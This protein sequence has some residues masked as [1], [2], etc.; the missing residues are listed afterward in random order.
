MCEKLAL[1]W[2]LA[3]IFVCTLAQVVLFFLLIPSLHFI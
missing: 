2:C 3:T 1:V